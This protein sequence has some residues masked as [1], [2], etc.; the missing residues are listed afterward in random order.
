[1][2]VPE[3][4]RRLPEPADPVTPAFRGFMDEVNRRGLHVLEV[5]GRDVGPD[6]RDWRSYLPGAASYTG[7]DVHPAPQVQIVGD[8]HWL[9]RQV[10]P[11]SQDAIWSTAVL[12]HLAQPWLAAVEI[13]R[14]LKLGGVTYQGAPHTWPLH[15]APAD[16]WRFSDEG[17]RVLFGPAFG[18]EVLATGLSEPVHVHPSRRNGLWSEMPVFPGYGLADVL[19]RKVAELPPPGAFEARLREHLP[20]AAR[21]YTATDRAAREQEARDAIAA[22]GVPAP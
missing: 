4:F 5:G 9:T 6:G 8:A 22:A 10:P 1:M 11:S 15:E 2:P 13:N 18:F 3:R 16:Y 17:L 14:A 21:L 20:D 19:A 12:E 7:F